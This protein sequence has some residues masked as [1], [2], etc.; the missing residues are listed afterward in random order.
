MDLKLGTV[1]AL[2][3]VMLVL[4]FAICTRIPNY[5]GQYDTKM[6]SFASMENMAL[7][8]YRMPKNA[9][10]DSILNEIKNRGIYYW[11]ENIVLVNGLDTLQLPDKLHKQDKMLLN[12]CNL[13]IK[14]YNLI[15]KAV[16]EDTDKYKDSIAACNKDIQAV[17]DSLKGK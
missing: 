10:K 9:P 14:S 15:Y 16:K 4:C 2:S 6:K 17:I 5:I 8:I 12:Y 11:K 1:G 3:L 7:E 13:R